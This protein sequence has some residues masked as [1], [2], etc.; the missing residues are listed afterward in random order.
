MERYICIHGHFYQPPRENAWLEFV[1]L[2]D[3]AYPFHDWNERITA[4]CYAPNGMSR[5][6]DGFQNIEKITN[7]YAH[8]SFNFG[9]TLLAWLADHEPETY[10][11]ILEADKESQQRFS[12]HGSAIAQAYNH[13][14][15]PLSNSR[16]KYTQILWGIRDFEFRFG[17]KPEGMWLPETAVDLETLEI[18]AGLDIR[19]TIL[20]PFQA[21]RTRK[22]RGR[23]WRDASGGRVDPSMPYNVRPPSVRVLRYP[24]VAADCSYCNRRRNLWSSS[25]KRRNGSRLRASSHRK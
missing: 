15:L 7:N 10:Q 13:T 25:Q 22:I 11:A 19:F 8:I 2:Q 9:P 3:S 24:D 17:R 20:S 4:E 5:I 12:G 18:L 6:L 21:K 23:A 1:E 16:D 14:I